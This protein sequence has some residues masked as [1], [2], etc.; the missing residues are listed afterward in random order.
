MFYFIWKLMK[1]FKITNPSKHFYNDSMNMEK[2]ITATLNNT[3]LFPYL[4]SYLI[5]WLFIYWY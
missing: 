1:I 4:G 2:M 5:A 3:Y